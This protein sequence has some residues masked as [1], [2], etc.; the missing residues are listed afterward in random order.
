MLAHALL[1][2]PRTIF[3]GT[4]LK[5]TV[6]IQAE[7]LRYLAQHPGAKDTA[8]GIAEWWMSA[9]PS[10]PT[11]TEVRDAMEDLVGRG[12][13]IAEQGADGRV[14]YRGSPLNEGNNN[15]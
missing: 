8:E 5:V 4:N 9:R 7:I 1:T 12:L 3:A 11:L 14:F 10:R 6:P 15:N 13:V 2:H